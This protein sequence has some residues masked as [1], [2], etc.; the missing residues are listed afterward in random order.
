MKNRKPIITKIFCKK[1]LF[2]QN[3]NP[4]DLQNDERMKL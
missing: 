3:T 2:R 4:E 1:K